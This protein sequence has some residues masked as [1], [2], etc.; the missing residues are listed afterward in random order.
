MT[1]SESNQCHEIG[2]KLISFIL[3]KRQFQFAEGK[4]FLHTFVARKTDD[5]IIDI[6]D[7]NID[8]K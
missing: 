4:T 6:S 8:H 1:L 2:L 7:T 5:R 3:T